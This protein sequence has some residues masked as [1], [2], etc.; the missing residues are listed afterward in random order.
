MSIIS[1]RMRAACTARFRKIQLQNSIH[2]LIL[3]ANVKSQILHGH[4]ERK[5]AHMFVL[6][7]AVSHSPAKAMMSNPVDSWLKNR[8]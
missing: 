6:A 2:M 3:L 5:R 8:G 4:D 1:L 7:V